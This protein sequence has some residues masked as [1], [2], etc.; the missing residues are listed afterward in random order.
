MKVLMLFMI[1]ATSLADGAPEVLKTRQL[2]AKKAGE[3]VKQIN[4]KG[5]WVRILRDIKGDKHKAQ[6]I[7]DYNPDKK[8]MRTGFIYAPGSKPLT[9]ME[10]QSHMEM[11]FKDITGA[12]YKPEHFIYQPHGGIAAFGWTKLYRGKLVILLFG[13][14]SVWCTTQEADEASGRDQLPSPTVP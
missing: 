13:E 9:L 2:E 6:F 7:H 3:T 11:L 4:Y 1:L 8:L 14:R 10:I 12:E 5:G